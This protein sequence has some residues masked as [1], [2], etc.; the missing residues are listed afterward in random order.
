MDAGGV[1]EEMDIDAVR[2]LSAWLSA[3]RDVQAHLDLL[4]GFGPHAEPQIA[5]NL[6]LIQELEGH[7]RLAF[8]NYR[9]HVV[10]RRATEASPPREP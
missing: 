7:A 2:L 5:R 1:D 8:Q 4:S 3:R 10:R 6:T 9:D